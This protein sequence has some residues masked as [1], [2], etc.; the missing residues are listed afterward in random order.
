MKIRRPLLR[1]IV[2]CAFIPFSLHATTHYVDLNS[3]NPTSPYTDW[4]HAATNIQDAVNSASGADVILVTNGVYQIGATF[5]AGSNRVAVTTPLTLESVNGPASTTIQGYQDPNNTNSVRCVYLANSATLSGFTLTGGSGDSLFG[6]GGGVYCDSASALVTNCVI[7]GNS[8]ATG[9]FGGGCYSGTLKN[10]VLS[11]NSASQ[12]GGAY[13]SSL[14]NCLVVSNQALVYGGG[15]FQGGY[16]NCTLAYN[17]AGNSGGGVYGGTGA[18]LDNC[19]AYFNNAPVSTS[20]NLTGAKMDYTCTAP[21]QSSATSISNAPLFAGLGDFHLSAASPCINAGLNSYASGTDLDGKPR[22]VGGTVDMGAYEFPA[23]MHY[24]CMGN[25][26]HFPVSPYTNW[27]SAATNIQ[28]AVDAAN[29]GDFVLVSNGVY[30]TGGRVGRG[31]ITNRVALTKAI[32]LQS[33]NGPAVTF[34]QGSNSASAF[35]RRCVYLTNNAALIGF[36]LTNGGTYLI[37]N[38]AAAPPLY[39]INTNYDFNG[40]GAWCEDTSSVISNCTIIN[41]IATWNGG[42]AYGGTLVNCSLTG[43]EALQG[44]AGYS[45][46]FNNCLLANNMT[47]YTVT[48]SVTNFG[49]GGA[50]FGATLNNCTVA[51]NT[52][53]G[54]AGAAAAS[55][56]LN[57]SIAYFNTNSSGTANANFDNTTANFSCTTPLPSSGTNDITNSPGFVNPGDGDFHLL[58]NS[59]C[60]NAG[61]NSF[62]ATSTDLDGNPRIRGETVDMGV[63]EFQADVSGQFVNWL[64]QNGLA[65]DGSADFTDPDGD[66]MNNW[67]EW[68]AGTDPNNPLSVLQ[69]LAPIPTNSASLIVTWQS[70]T[71]RNYYVQ[72]STNL[73]TSFTAVQ[74]NIVGQA[75]TT[76]YIDTRA[77]HAGPFFYRVGVQ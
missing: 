77:N 76:T 38:P 31:D 55:C 3:A 24:V 32:T 66:G 50:A 52:A 13:T 75:G 53:P 65:T 42:G 10:C 18:W 23:A 7:T 17:S 12:G 26:S 62:V 15:G 41:D 27:S 70:V 46:T 56:T 59:R 73:Q 11:E 74:S 34:I 43:N 63:Y 67:Q 6:N 8:A 61:Q 68:F 71:G 20:S 40:A 28:D 30:Q 1:S 51:G 37:P 21:V 49:D 36:T 54:P 60:I 64:Q 69:V 45:N 25:P 2:A 35:P 14:L 4:T 57:N 5:I 48:G 9:G 39:S 22:I 44:G 33:V 29:S 47:Y 58:G 16:T 72:R 19:I